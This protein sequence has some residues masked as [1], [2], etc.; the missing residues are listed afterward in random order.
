MQNTAKQN[1]PVELSLTV[2]SQETRQ[3]YSTMLLSPPGA[4]LAELEYR[5]IQVTSFKIF[6]LCIS[7]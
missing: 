6:P 5:K 2:L 1:Y 7:S 3:A 4:I